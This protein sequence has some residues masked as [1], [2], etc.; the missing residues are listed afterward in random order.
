MAHEISILNDGTAE[1]AY[2]LKGAWHGLGTVLDTV[3]DSET[4]LKAANLDWEVDLIDLHGTVKG[5]REDGRTIASTQKM[6]VRTDNYTELGIV[7]D[8]YGVVQNREAFSFLDSLFQDGIMRYESAMALRG[9]RVIAVLA[10][11]PSVVDE[12]ADGDTCARYCLFQTSH[13][14]SMNLRAI[15]T[16][17]RVVCMNTL[18]MAISASGNIEGV[19]H[20]GD[21]GKKLDYLRKYLSQFDAKFTLFRDKARQLATAKIDA[22]N[23]SHADAVR[24]YID[25]LFP[26]VEVK[27]GEPSRAKTIR[28]GKVAAIRRNYRNERQM[29]PSIRNSW[30]SLVNSVTELV[31]HGDEMVFKGKGRERDENKFMNVVTGDGAAFKSKAFDLACEAVGV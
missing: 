14:G 10:R 11:M 4:M 19:R 17:V 27:P 3:P 20:I 25:T 9:G 29:L 26:P 18:R 30:W 13:D 12:I 15:P 2:A 1:A 23:S 6:V 24:K 5:G 16:S 31:D 8:N 7:G 22:S 28:D 21:M